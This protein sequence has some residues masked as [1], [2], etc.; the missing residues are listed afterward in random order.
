MTVRKECCFMRRSTIMLALACALGVACSSGRSTTVRSPPA[1]DDTGGGAV[2]SAEFPTVDQLESLKQYTP[3]EEER[4]LPTVLPTDW[5][6]KGPFPLESA[7]KPIE[8]QG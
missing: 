6:L 1:D 5:P 4:A 2:T 7:Q 8:T 3:P